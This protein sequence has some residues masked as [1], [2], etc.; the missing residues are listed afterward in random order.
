MG[1][2]NVSLLFYFVIFGL[3]VVQ[4]VLKMYGNKT[5]FMYRDT[6][7]PIF[8]LYALGKIMRKS[9]IEAHSQMDF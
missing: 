3:K 9:S 2:L 8:V 1:K 7:S 4:I 5:T 6:T